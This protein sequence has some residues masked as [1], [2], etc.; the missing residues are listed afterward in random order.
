M[1]THARFA[2]VARS[3]GLL[4]GTFGMA[5]ASKALAFRIAFPAFQCS[6]DQFG[7]RK[8]RNGAMDLPWG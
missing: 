6:A 7:A 4:G 2:R 3:G 1:S 8:P 5:E